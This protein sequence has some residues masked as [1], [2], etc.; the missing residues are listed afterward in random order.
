M[1][2]LVHFINNICLPAK[3]YLAIVFVNFFT[4]LL[5]KK[6]NFKFALTLFVFVAFFGFLM[7]WFGNYLCS[8]GFTF[9]TWLFVILPIYT[10]L[11]NVYTLLKK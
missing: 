10:L 11:N 2:E 8:K 6:K 5:L 9:V 4:M 1:S 7:A 3:I